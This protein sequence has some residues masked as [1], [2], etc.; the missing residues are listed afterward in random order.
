MSRRPT[1]SVSAFAN[2]FSPALRA[3]ALAA[4][5]GLPAAAHEIPCAHFHE[6]TNR[7]RL[8]SCNNPNSACTDNGNGGTCKNVQDNYSSICTCVVPQSGGCASIGVQYFDSQD[9]GPP[10]P[11]AHIIYLAEPDPSNF[12]SVFVSAGPGVHFE[13][14][15]SFLGGTFTVVFP[16]FE[17]NETEILATLDNVALSFAPVFNSG[18]NYVELEDGFPQLV[19][20]DSVTGILKP[21]GS[22]GLHL[23]LDNNHWTNQPI[24][25]WF[26][27]RLQP[28]GAV[29]LF[30][31][32]SLESVL[33][34][35]NFESGGT[36]LWSTA[37]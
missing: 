19:L 11:N 36:S 32:H 6:P 16:P 4:T 14:E 12:A 30:F 7:D 28:G 3:A 8:I 13:A 22:E 18:T 31:Q 34:A 37:P 23:H 29:E 5:L 9:A 33:F 26:E 10:S 25:V 35:D 21:L 2:R 24:T 27:A 20:Y 17:E 15:T 1:D